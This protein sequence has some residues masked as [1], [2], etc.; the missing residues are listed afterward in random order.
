MNTLRSLITAVGLGAGLMYLFDPEGGPHRRAELR[1][2]IDGL[3]HGVGYAVHTARGLGDRAGGLILETRHVATGQRDWR[4]IVPRRQDWTKRNWAPTPRSLAIMGGGLMLLSS[5]GHGRVA[6]AGK[7]AGLALL[8][9]SVAKV[10]HSHQEESPQVPPG[11]TGAFVG[12]YD[13]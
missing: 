7:F 6:T 4:E 9:R 5:M 8:A 3:R 11:E 10:R 12:D 13:L 2:Q 1:E